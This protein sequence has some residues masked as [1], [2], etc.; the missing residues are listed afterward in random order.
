MGAQKMCIRT[1]E[2]LKQVLSELKALG[3]EKVIGVD[4]AGRGPIAGPV[5]AAA[6]WLPESFSALHELRD[7]KVL[8]EKMRLRLYRLLRK[9]A[10]IGIGTASPREIDRLNIS[11]ATLLAMWRAIHR[12]KFEPDAVLIDGTPLGELP[13]I[14]IWVIGGDAMCP[15]I[16]AASIVA[17]VV[18]D[19]HM[20]RAHK[21]YPQYGF[22]SHKGYAT[23]LHKR[24]LVENG[25]C[26]IHRLSFAP[27]RKA[28]IPRLLL[29]DAQ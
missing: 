14:C 10:I 6:V 19:Q 7:S 4:E 23:A 12:L 28:C 24:M 22:N 29:E 21:L 5:V 9:E 17:K 11:A 8:T 16:S 15:Q 26:P 1:R 2:Q 18:R 25:P 13:Y 27:V 20:M 3:C